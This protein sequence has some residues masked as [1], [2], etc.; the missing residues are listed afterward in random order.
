MEHVQE[1]SSCMWTL[2]LQKSHPQLGGVPSLPQAATP[3]FRSWV[4]PS[5]PPQPSGPGHTPGINPSLQVLS[6]PQPSLAHSLPKQQVL[7]TP[8]LKDIWEVG[9][10]RVKAVK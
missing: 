6:A 8:P 5:P 1:C 7:L 3:A 9:L 2:S 4:H 10:S